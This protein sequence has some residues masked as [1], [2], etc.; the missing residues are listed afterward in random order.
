MKQKNLISATII[1]QVEDNSIDFIMIDG[2][3][4]YEAVKADI[5]AFLPKMNCV[6]NR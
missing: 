3:H 5:L 4:E 2:A 6:I 1:A